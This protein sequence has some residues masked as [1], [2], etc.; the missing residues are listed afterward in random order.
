[1]TDRPPNVVLPRAYW[2]AVSFLVLVVGIGVAWQVGGGS[3]N[4]RGAAKPVG[5]DGLVH[6]DQ[7]GPYSL[8]VF[9][10]ASR[11]IDASADRA[12][13]TAK[14]ATVVV[15][16]D[17]SGAQLA[18]RNVYET[19]DLQNT[20]VARLVEFE[21]TAP[22]TF[23]VQITPPL[24]ELKPAI[25]PSAPLEDLGRMVAR[26][27]IGLGIGALATV[28]AAAIF[29]VVLIRRQKYRRQPATCPPPA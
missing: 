9:R 25:R 23:R 17:R 11:R 22:G 27:L 10:G 8:Y 26:L 13:N 19:S 20:R 6:L 21:V 2:Y 12:W 7:V 5:G 14:T 3:S 15:R 24:D 16:D 4:M 28:I 18:L 1:M 29:F